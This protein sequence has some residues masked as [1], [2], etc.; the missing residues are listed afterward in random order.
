MAAWEIERKVCLFRSM[1]MTQ[2]M[3]RQIIGPE[4]HVLTWGPHHTAQ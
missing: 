2:G 1:F 3:N 4:E